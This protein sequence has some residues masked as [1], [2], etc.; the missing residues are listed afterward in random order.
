MRLLEWKNP[1]KQ[2]AYDVK[3][4]GGLPWMVFLSP[5]FTAA[6]G[7]SCRE[8]SSTTRR[9]ARTL[10]GRNRGRLLKP[11]ATAQD[12][13]A[14]PVCTLYTRKPAQLALLLLLAPSRGVVLGL[15]PPLPPS[16]R[17][18]CA[19]IALLRSVR[20]VAAPRPRAVLS[21]SPFKSLSPVRASRDPSH[22]PTSRAVFSTVRVSGLRRPARWQGPI[23][24]LQTVMK[25]ALSRSE[26]GRARGARGGV[27]D[28]R[29]RPPSSGAP[30]L[31][32]PHRTIAGFRGTGAPPPQA[33]E[34]L[35]RRPRPSRLGDA[36]CVCV[37]RASVSCGHVP[38][39]A[40]PR[41][42]LGESL[43]GRRPHG[44]PM[45]GIVGTGST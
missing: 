22:Y 16:A 35:Q 25:S 34:R 12:A 14:A 24:S 7:T 43:P 23:K 13:T 28:R 37:S 9:L 18:A 45:A 2:C 8:C 31:P 6:N 10:T 32:G 30:A 19:A 5:S 33:R 3:A 44:P 21:E 1:S 36:P 20:R 40:A 15:G 17:R 29:R 42:P 26:H 41:A 11:V 4:I 39:A 27:R 38:R